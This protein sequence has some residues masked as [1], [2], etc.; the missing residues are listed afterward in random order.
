MSNQIARKSRHQVQIEELLAALP[1]GAP[2][3]STAGQ[4]FVT[5]PGGQTFPLSS[6]YVRDWLTNEYIKR[7]SAPPA[8]LKREPCMR[9]GSSDA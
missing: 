7:H 5:L 1:E 6:A 9:P 8:A 4:V 3:V 2:F